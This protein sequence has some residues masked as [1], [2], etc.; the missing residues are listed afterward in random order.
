MTAIPLAG[1]G[2]LAA[3]A[4]SGSYF[5]LRYRRLPNWLCLAAFVA[6]LAFTLASI[7]WLAAG[8]ALLHAMLALVIGAVLFALG[9]VGGGD[10]KYYAGLA[11]WYPVSAG[12]TLLVSVA[13]TGLV[14]LLAWLPFRRRIHLHVPARSPRRK[15]PYGIAIA[16][17]SLMA[18]GLQQGWLL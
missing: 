3:L 8:S 16:G 10:A 4:L 12:L 11:G 2:V 17:G 15:V 18:F 5:D 1:A 13:L 7:G 9:G 14:V 6:G